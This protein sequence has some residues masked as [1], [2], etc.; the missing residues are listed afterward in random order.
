MSRSPLWKQAKN[1][2]FFFFSVV[3]MDVYPLPRI[4]IL[5]KNKKTINFFQLKI[6]NFFML[7]RICSLHVHVFKMWMFKNS[8]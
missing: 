1:S 5:S 6:L 8:I 3:E 7:G 2:D 4:Y